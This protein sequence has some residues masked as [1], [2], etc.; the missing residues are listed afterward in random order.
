MTFISGG[1]VP[2]NILPLRL[3][4]SRG[5]LRL[6]LSVRYTVLNLAAFRDRPAFRVSTSEYMYRILDRGEREL[7]AYH[8]HPQG[9]SS[10]AHP[11][12][13]LS[14]VEPFVLSLAPNHEST[15]FSV[16]K[17]HFPTGPV[18]LQRIIRL[19]IEDLGVEPRRPDW[20]DVLCSSD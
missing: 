6:G 16:D 17:A 11:H 15:E 3:R 20:R 13:H 19:L 14:G 5:D 8:W 1:R 9:L 7:L 2:P 10:I 18:T 4:N 12:L